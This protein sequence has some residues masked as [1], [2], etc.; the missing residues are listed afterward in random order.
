[1][2]QYADSFTSD[3]SWNQTPADNVE[4][5]RE[6]KRDVGLLVDDSS[7]GTDQKGDPQLAE[8]G[9]PSFNLEKANT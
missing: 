5:L 1:M 4:W 2:S 6:F 8:G 3:D 7:S 9:T